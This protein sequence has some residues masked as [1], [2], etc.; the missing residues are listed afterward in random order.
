MREEKIVENS[1][2]REAKGSA[3]KLQG[4]EDK[5]KGPGG[6]LHRLDLLRS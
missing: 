1:S 2:R 6:L 5:R 4:L 3:H